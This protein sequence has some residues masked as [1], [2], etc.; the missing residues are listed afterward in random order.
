MYLEQAVNPSRVIQRVSMQS[1]AVH[2][3]PKPPLPPYIKAEPLFTGLFFLELF[4]PPIYPL[5]KHC[6][7]DVDADTEDHAWDATKYGLI[8]IRS[9]Q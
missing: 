8:H 3:Q 2:Q 9:T 6:L 4:W 7:G 1:K 5:P